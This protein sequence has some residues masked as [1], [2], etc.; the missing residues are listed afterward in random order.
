MSAQMETQKSKKRSLKLNIAASLIIQVVSLITNLIS[1]GAIKHYLGVDYLGMQSVYANFCDVMSF[2]FFGMGT[3]MLFSLYGPFARNEKEKQAAYFQYYDRIYQKIS[4]AVLAFGAVST[5]AMVVLIRSEIEV[6]EICCTYLLFMLSVVLYNR[7]LVRNFFI[8]A[9]QKRYVV[10]IATGGVDI[11]ALAVQIFVLK[12]FH[13]YI[14]MVTGI[15]FKNLLINALLKIYLKKEYPYIFRNEASL[16]EEEKQ[17]TKENIVSMGIYRF[18]NVLINNTDS[19]YISYFINTATVGIYTNYMFIITGIR[20]LISALYEAIRGRVGH[21]IQTSSKEKQYQGFVINAL[22]NSW[23]M[24]VCVVC[25]YFLVQDFI[26]LWMGEIDVFPEKILW[27]LLINFYLEASHNTIR[28]YRESMGM[29]QK[30]RNAILLKG[31]MNIILSYFGGKLFGLSGIL[32]ATTIS[33]FTTLFW[34]E[35]K[36]VYAYY[37]KNFLYE[38]FYH[39][40]TIA[41]MAVSFFLTDLLAGDMEANTIGSFIIKASLCAG[42]SNLIYLPVFLL[43]ILKRKR[44][45]SYKMQE[46][47]P[48]FDEYPYLCSCFHIKRNTKVEQREADA[49]ELISPYRLDFMSKILLLEAMNGSYDI[50]KA[51]HLYERHLYAFSSGIMI[52]PGQKEKSGIQSYLDAFSQIEKST[53]KEEALA[54]RLGAPVPVDAKLMA[55]DGAHRIC[56]AIYYHKWIPVYFLNRTVPNKYDYLFF[57]RRF[58]EEKLILEMVRKYVKMKECCLY[59]LPKS[60]SGHSLRK[61]Y[62]TYAPVYMK[63]MNSKEV[64]LLLDLPYIRRLGADSGAERLNK[65]VMVDSSQKIIGYLLENE[66]NLVKQ[67]VFTKT[68]IRYASFLQMVWAYTRRIINSMLRR[69]V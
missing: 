30:I 46:R 13:S 16:L 31:I 24:G 62:K 8:Q 26:R 65:Y 66:A 59:L 51:E 38:L 18:G 2:A 14:L 55:M 34:Y 47:N 11:L 41:F 25:F 7:Q 67:T 17:K 64:V 19:I 69:P 23:L 39:G 60:I 9:D 54:A 53:K 52:E 49:K 29:F 21:Q 32:I 43:Y 15:L 37:K 6:I 27:I 4:I 12:Y 61:I 36:I 45:K 3:A 40:I 1:K 50:K 5:T 10:A 68:Y 35:A 56:S 22:I 48:F 63:K 33:S 44:S 57:R 58:L 42:I 20:S 28:I